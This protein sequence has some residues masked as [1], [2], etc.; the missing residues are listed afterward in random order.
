[1]RFILVVVIF[2]YS[3]TAYADTKRLLLLGDSLSAAY[4]MEEHDG[5]VHLVQEWLV[6]TQA[7]LE[8]I[9]ASMSGETT[10]GGLA[11]LP[12]LLQSY[13]PDYVL[14]ELG[15]NDGL[16]G[17]RIAQIEH[18]L[19]QMIELIQQNHAQ[20]ILMQIRIPPNLGPRYTG[21]FEDLYLSLS[22]QYNVALWPFFMQDIA[23][24]NDL[25]MPDGIHPN[26]QAQPLIK[27]QM[28]TWFAELAHHSK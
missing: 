7:P 6:T 2:V 5:W 24:D 21:Q 28:K 4:N 1:M 16:R 10:G 15:G 11:R 20:P 17:F 19:L 27:Q 13:Q 26:R 22:N 14:I 9:N 8:I 25:M 23:L 12:A 18:N 3:T